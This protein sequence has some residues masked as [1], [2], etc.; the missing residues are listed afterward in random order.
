MAEQHAVGF[1]GLMT[2]SDLEQ[3]V[4]DSVVADL[5]RLTGGANQVCHDPQHHAPDA[6]GLRS[7]QEQAVDNALAGACQTSNQETAHCAV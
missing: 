3:A 7:Q 1:E 6:A 2:A 5:D 4:V